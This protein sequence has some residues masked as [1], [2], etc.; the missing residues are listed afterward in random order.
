[1]TFEQKL[2][3]TMIV[4]AGI[5]AL[6]TFTTWW[7]AIIGACTGATFVICIRLFMRH[8]KRNFAGTKK[9]DWI[10]LLVASSIAFLC[11]FVEVYS[12]TGF[13]L[14]FV[15]VRALIMYFSSNSADAD[16]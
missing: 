10:L 3:I 16:A 14:I 7:L 12:L 8:S 15:S 2:H 9:L 11:M 4:A 1:M 13:A 6:L 5:G